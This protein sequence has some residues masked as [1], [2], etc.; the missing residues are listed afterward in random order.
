MP[1]VCSEDSATILALY[2]SIVLAVGDRKV[3]WFNVSVV[4]VGYGDKGVKASAQPVQAST[5][6]QPLQDIHSRE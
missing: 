1:G 4:K 5:S 2:L 6:V 3:T